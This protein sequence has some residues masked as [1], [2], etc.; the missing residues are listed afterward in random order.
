MSGVACEAP[1]ALEDREGKHRHARGPPPPHFVSCLH[2]LRGPRSL[3]WDLEHRLRN[4]NAVFRL[5]NQLA[6]SQR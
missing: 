3:F 6:I 1:G 4:P 2:H 5:E